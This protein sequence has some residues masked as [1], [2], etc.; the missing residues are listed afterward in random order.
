VTRVAIIG[1]GKMGKA[2]AA[3]APDKDCQVVAMIGEGQKFELR[4]A[5][6]AI[7]FT[8]PDAAPANIRKCLD[9]GVPVV[10]GTTGW[11]GELPAIREEVRK[12]NS[13][14]L[15]SAN[16]SVGVNVVIQLARKAGELLAGND[17]FKSAM[18]ETH[19]AEKKDA[20]SGTAKVI[21]AALRETLG[22][23]TPI[24]SVRTGTVVGTHELS[25]EG[26]FETI[27]I[28][29]TAHDRRLF[30]E[31]A[32]QAARWLVGKRGVF[33]MADVL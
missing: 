10:V 16:F 17:S 24:S 6:V 12:R 23:E 4:D 20:P 5:E 28:T 31:G 18:V 27:T 14:L 1:D 32:L 13:A 7:E 9:A 29:H 19:H 25:F 33:T 15:W 26:R 8:Q 22:R 11:Y 30:A 3:L 21:E 2:L